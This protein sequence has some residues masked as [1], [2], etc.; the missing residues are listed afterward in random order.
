[1]KVA[2]LMA[3]AVLLCLAGVAVANDEDAPKKKRPARKRPNGIFGKIVKVEGANLV[4]AKRTRGSKETTEVTVATD[5]NTKFSLDRN[6]ATL[7]DMKAGL[8]VFITPETGTAERVRAMTELRRRPKD[9]DRDKD[10]KKGKKS[11]K[12]E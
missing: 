5:D 2:R 9:K 12:E 10:G 4:V 1:M 6:E 7:A 11:P 8:F 3:L